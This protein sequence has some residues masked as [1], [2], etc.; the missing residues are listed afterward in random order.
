MMIREQR[1]R[2]PYRFIDSISIFLSISISYRFE[3]KYRLR[4]INFDINIENIVRF[5]VWL[6]AF[7]ARKTLAFEFDFRFSRT[8]ERRR[9]P[10]RKR[11]EL[12]RHE[13][14][15]FEQF[16]AKYITG[17]SGILNYLNFYMLHILKIII[18]EE[19]LK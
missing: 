15:E 12:R 7:I 19:H 4:S 13:N 17:H 2:Y 10:T 14:D 11:W 3:K 5:R 18:L 8:R 16:E 9:R 6:L 1:Y